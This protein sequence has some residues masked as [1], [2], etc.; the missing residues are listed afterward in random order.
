M[1]SLHVRSDSG[2]SMLFN[3]LV[4]VASSVADIIF[5]TQIILKIFKNTLRLITGDFDFWILI[6]SPYLGF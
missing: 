6:S 5:I 4:E 2:R 1:A 3:S